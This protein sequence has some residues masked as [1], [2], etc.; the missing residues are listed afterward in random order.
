M[1]IFDLEERQLIHLYQQPE[2]AFFISA[3]KTSLPHVPE[4]DM[5]EL[6]QTLIGKLEGITDGDYREI[7]AQP[8]ENWSETEVGNEQ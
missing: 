5:A 6:M 4:Q 1:G 8:Y 3:L 2:R 7:Y